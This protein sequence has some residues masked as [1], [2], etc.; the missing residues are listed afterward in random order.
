MEI[1]LIILL[2]MYLVRWQACCGALTQWRHVIFWPCFRPWNLKKK[3]LGLGKLFESISTPIHVMAGNQIVRIPIDKLHF[4][5]I[6][7]FMLKCIYRPLNESVW[8]RYERRIFNKLWSEWHVLLSAIVLFIC[9]GI[10]C[11]PKVTYLGDFY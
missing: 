7:A 1:V 5:R 11:I 3:K 2:F 6:H 8:F 4:R 9:R 10:S